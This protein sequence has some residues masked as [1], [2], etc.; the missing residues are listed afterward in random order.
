MHGLI[1]GKGSLWPTAVLL[2]IPPEEGEEII[3]A[4]H[5]GLSLVSL[6]TIRFLNSPAACDISWL[7]DWALT[8]TTI[9]SPGLLPNLEMMEVALLAMGCTSPD[10]GSDAHEY[11]SLTLEVQKQVIFT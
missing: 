5:L 2:H 6:L 11:L 1:K 9:F 8:G 10:E 4:S 7:Q 3:S